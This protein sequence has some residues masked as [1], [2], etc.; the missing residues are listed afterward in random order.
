MAEELPDCIYSGSMDLDVYIVTL[1]WT[2]TFIYIM[3]IVTFKTSIVCI[4][5]ILYSFII[6]FLGIF[7]VMLVVTNYTKNTHTAENIIIIMSVLTRLW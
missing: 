1:A 5:D 7:L 4:L 6:T 3:I 2:H